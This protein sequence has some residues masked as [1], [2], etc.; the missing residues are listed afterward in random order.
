MQ[1]LA[2]ARESLALYTDRRMLAIFG[3]GVASGLPLLLTTGTLSYWL[4]KSGVDKTSIG[5][6]AL[7]GLPYSFKFLWAPVLDHVRIPVLGPRLGQRRSWALVAQLALIVCIAGLGATDPATAPWAT[8]RL[9]VAIAFFS[10][11]QDIAIDAYRIEVLADPEQGAGAAA[12]QTGYR[13]GLLAAGAG[14]IAL[15]DFVPWRVV[16]T[17]MAAVMGIGV[18]SALLGPAPPSLA[19]ATREASGSA[20][21]ER[22]L[23]A[24][25]RD[26]S[27][28]PMWA[29]ILAF[30]MLYKFGDAVAGV[31]ANKFYVDLGFSGVEIA[32]VT[33]VL[34]LAASIGGVLVGGVLVAQLGIYRALALGGLLQV[35]SLLLFAFAAHLGH[36]LGG[37]ALAV[38]ADSFSSGIAG[39]ALVAYLSSLCRGAYTATQYALLT[40]LMA[41]GRTALASGAGWLAAQLDWAHF[42]SATALLAAPGLLLLLWI[43]RATRA[44]VP[45]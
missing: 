17:A 43:W 15:A 30:A 6:F 20:L 2:R 34:G 39:A 3:M 12:T 40:S 31:M 44:R 21:L 27:L 37:L 1:P 25:L 18:A 8:A 32:S 11:T 13:I 4:A 38:G 26:F 14:A 35:P 45:G 16:F 42:F 7:V 28:R 33:K 9:A 23:L 19:P 10:A 41:A 24:P 22:A 5:L 36:D 29:A